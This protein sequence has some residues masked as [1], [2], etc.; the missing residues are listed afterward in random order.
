MTN[1]MNCY[2]A[3]DDPRDGNAGVGIP[4][5]QIKKTI[6]ETRRDTAIWALRLIQTQIR[7][8]HGYSAERQVMLVDLVIKQ[9]IAVLDGESDEIH[10]TFI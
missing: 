7:K 2:D 5:E 6:C 8:N 10:V 1:E 4:V 3:I 9:V